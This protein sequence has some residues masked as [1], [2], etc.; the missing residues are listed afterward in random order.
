[1]STVRHIQDVAGTVFPAGRHTR[2]LVGRPGPSR[3]SASSW[4]TSP[5]SPA[6]RFRST[7]EQEEVYY[8]AAG[9]GAMEVAGISQPVKAGSYVDASGIPAHPA[10]GPEWRHLP[11]HPDFLDKVLETVATPGGEVAHAWVPRR[12]LPTTSAWF[13][14]AWAACRAGE[15]YE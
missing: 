8:I 2:V 7:H 11:V 3:P 1:M 10:L 9:E 12:P 6:E 14:T 15:I 4:G 5:S 13:E